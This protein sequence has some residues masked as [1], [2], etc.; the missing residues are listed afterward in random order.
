MVGIAE[1]NFQGRAS[2]EEVGAFKTCLGN[3]TTGL[4]TPEHFPTNKQPLNPLLYFIALKLPSMDF[5]K[6]SKPYIGQKRENVLVIDLSG[7]SKKRSFI[8]D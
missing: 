5:Q 7:E 1:G 4:M 3:M 2:K 6:L 8:T